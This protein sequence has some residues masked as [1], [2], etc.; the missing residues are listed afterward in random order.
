LYICKTEE[1]VIL[2]DRYATHVR[3]AWYKVFNEDFLSTSDYSRAPKGPFKEEPIDDS[4]Q[5]T[6]TMRMVAGQD[7]LD[8]SGVT[9]WQEHTMQTRPQDSSRSGMRQIRRDNGFRHDLSIPRQAWQNGK[10]EKC[11]EEF[12]GESVFGKGRSTHSVTAKEGQKQQPQFTLHQYLGWQECDGGLK[13]LEP[14]TLDSESI[15]VQDQPTPSHSLRERRTWR[16]SFI[17]THTHG[18]RSTRDCEF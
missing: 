13:K 1:F 5:S 3:Y 2:R 14:A 10:A 15:Q 18:K 7:E 4:S 9:H 16:K 6:L 11:H 17:H 8:E 12:L